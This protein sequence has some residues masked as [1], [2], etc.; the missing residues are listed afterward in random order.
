M[1]RKLSGEFEAVATPKR[2]RS[3]S[4]SPGSSAV[5][6]Y[7]LDYM[8]G[9]SREKEAKQLVKT[10]SPAQQAALAEIEAEPPAR[11]D[12]AAVVL[13]PP[14]RQGGRPK[15]RRDGKAVKGVRKIRADPSAQAKLQLSQTLKQL[16][17]Q[18]GVSKLAARRQVSRQYGLSMSAV[19]NLEKPEVVAKLTEFVEKRQTGKTGLRRSGSHLA[20]SKMSSLSEGKRVAQKGKTLGKTDWCRPVWQQT[21]IWSQTEE[22]NGHVLSMADLKRDYVHRLEVAIDQKEAAGESGSKQVAAW[23]KKLHSLQNNESQAQARKSLS[24]DSER[25]RCRAETAN[26]DSLADL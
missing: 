23:K 4:G 2:A 21:C 20:F 1:K 17:Q 25:V 26:G 24:A 9:Q 19:K 8:F 16:Q 6:F 5:K 18:P 3:D 12:R 13:R 15:G 7:R 14:N 10:E 11:V 22:G